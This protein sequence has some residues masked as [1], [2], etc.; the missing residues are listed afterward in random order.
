MSTQDTFDPAAEAA[1]IAFDRTGKGE[2]VLLISGFPQTRRSWNRIVPRLSPAYQAIAADLPNFGDPGFLPVPATTENVGAIFH[3]FVGKLPASVHVVA[4]DFG[5]PPVSFWME[6]NPLMVLLAD[7]RV[8]VADALVVFRRTQVCFDR[9][10][11]GLTRPWAF[12]GR[13]ADQGRSRKSHPAILT[14]SQIGQRDRNGV[15]MPLQRGPVI[16]AEFEDGDPPATNP[17]LVP[18]VL[19]GRDQNVEPVPLGR[20]EE[21]AVA[22][23]MPTHLKG[24]PDFDAGEDRPQTSRDAVIE[25]GSQA[26]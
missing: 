2:P 6:I 19:V 9:G 17:V 21:I 4:H 11:G 15:S 16:G 13:P 8:E 23:L 10:G 3:E 14:R 7:H 20:P 22:Q 12:R 1:K 5:A 24:V 18:N 25:K 26:R